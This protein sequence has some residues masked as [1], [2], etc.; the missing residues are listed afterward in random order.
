MV[1]LGTSVILW[2]R[3]PEESGKMKAAMTPVSPRGRP[4]ANIGK[5]CQTIAKVATKG[6]QRLKTLAT[7]EQTLM[8]V[9]LRFVGY[10]SDDT[11][12][13]RV[14]APDAKNL[15]LKETQSAIVYKHMS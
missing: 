9:L 12:K 8:A 6:V 15:A 10:S 2:G 5:G 7:V 13:V 1:T 14:K 3:L 4:M 11:M